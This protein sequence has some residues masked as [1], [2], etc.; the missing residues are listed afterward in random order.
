MNEELEEFEYEELNLDAI[1]ET[2]SKLLGGKVTAKYN[3]ENEDEEEIFF[4]HIIPQIEKSQKLE[5]EIY[6]L[7]GIDTS[8]VT[9]PLWEVVEMFLISKYGYFTKEVIIDWII[10]R[11]DDDGNLLPLEIYNEEGVH[12]LYIKTV[13]ELFKYVKKKK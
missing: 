5:E 6:Q 10:N 13:E 2:F 3:I 9:N 8:S 11:Y 7:S 4:K 1:S 12:K